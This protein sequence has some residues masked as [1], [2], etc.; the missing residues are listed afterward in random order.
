[1][2]PNRTTSTKP[3]GAVA[4]IAGSQDPL[5]IR[6]FRALKSART[7]LY[8]IKPFLV[9]LRLPRDKKRSGAEGNRG[10]FVQRR[11]ST[12]E[13]KRITIAAQFA[14]SQRQWGELRTGM[15]VFKRNRGKIQM[16]VFRGEI[17]GKNRVGFVPAAAHLAPEKTRF[18]GVTFPAC[19]WGTSARP[20]RGRN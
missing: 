18:L 20:P 17:I 16:Y 11:E 6:R 7:Q 5:Q 13:P 14:F 9:F 10:I 15:R 12:H 2:K 4:E 3:Q 8:E 19:S 1:M